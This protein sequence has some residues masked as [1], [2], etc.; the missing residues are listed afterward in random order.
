MLLEELH[1]HVV[2]L[3][4]MH[5]AFLQRNVVEHYYL[6][7]LLALLDNAADL[8]DFVFRCRDVHRVGV[9]DAEAEVFVGFELI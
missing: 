7:D 8:G 9:V 4:D 3:A 5:F 6:A 2:K 1:A